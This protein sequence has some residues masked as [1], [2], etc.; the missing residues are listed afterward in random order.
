MSYIWAN[1]VH[2]RRPLV[3][4]MELCARR[5]SAAQMTPWLKLSVLQRFSTRPAP[6]P[7]K[8]DPCFASRCMHTNADQAIEETHIC[9][10][11]RKN[12]ND[13]TLEARSIA[14]LLRQRGI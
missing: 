12:D 7:V 14:K 2:A 8:H 11:Y 1:T 4:T 10:T 3:V 9:V 5:H 6:A 13:Q